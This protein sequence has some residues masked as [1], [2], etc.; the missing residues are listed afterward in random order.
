MDTKTLAAF[1]LGAAIL[2]VTA[3]GSGSRAASGGGGTSGAAGGPAL[4][5][6]AP[7]DG[8]T[9]RLPVT[10]T[11]TS[12]KAIGPESSGKDH[13]HLVIDGRTDDY[14]VV[15]STTYQIKSLPAGR[16]TIG[17]TLQHADHSSDDASAQ[18]T[19]DVSGGGTTGGDGNNGNSGN[20]GY[21]SGTGGNDRYDY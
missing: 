6:T 21:D 7:R 5:I 3:C 2:G 11:F 19:V 1:G 12:R 14:T 18:V 13:V 9:V 10:L 17:L 4:V 16:H 15:T 20:N 8:A